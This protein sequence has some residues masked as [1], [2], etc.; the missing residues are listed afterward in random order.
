MELCEKAMNAGF[1]EKISSLT[2]NV[3]S[4][5]PESKLSIA[6]RFSAVTGNQYTMQ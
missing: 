3:F 2:G 6:I 5:I 4:K 1:K